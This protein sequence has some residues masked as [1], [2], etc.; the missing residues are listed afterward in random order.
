MCLLSNRLSYIYHPILFAE[1]NMMQ[2]FH[3]WKPYQ[4]IHRSSFA[5]KQHNVPSTWSYLQTALNYRLSPAACTSK[6]PLPF[7]TAFS[8]LFTLTSLSV[9]SS[10]T[11][12]SRS[13]I[14]CAM[15]QNCLLLFYFPFWATV[16]KGCDKFDWYYHWCDSWA[17]CLILS[18]HVCFK[19]GVLLIDTTQ[20]QFKLN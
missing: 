3:R 5:Q 14:S 11:S 18:R 6:S 19:E 16:H 9:T 2:W 15:A 17:Y 4:A 10:Y 1:A 13:D 20:R 12:L 7:L 8:S